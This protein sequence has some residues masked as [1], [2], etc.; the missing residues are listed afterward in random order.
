M[1]IVTPDGKVLRKKYD[2]EAEA[3]AEIRQRATIVDRSSNASN[4]FIDFT[5]ERGEIWAI[6]L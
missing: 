6:K 3:E 4:N 5:D 2:T 1:K